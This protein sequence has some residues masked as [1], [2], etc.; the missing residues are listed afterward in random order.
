[1]VSPQIAKSFTVQA[2]AFEDAR[3]NQVLGG[4]AGWLF[5]A[6]TLQPDDL[7]LDVAAG[8]GH[9]ARALASRVRAVVAVDATEAMLAAGQAAA[10]REGLSN[11]IFTRGDA[12]ALPF[13]DGSFTAA[14]CRYAVHHFPDPAAPLAEMARCL[15]R[16]GR[17]VVADLVT[18]GD[19]AVA[20]RTDELERLRDPSHERLRSSD[21]LAD[22]VRATGARVTHR[23][24]RDVKRPVS[25]WLALTQT[26]QGAAAEIVSQLDAELA[27]GPAT[28]LV[29]CRNAGE[30]WFTQ[31]YTSITASL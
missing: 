8:T 5:E 25:D 13:L 31:T 16:P 30:L 4:G 3:F 14:V 19:P 7:L 24:S 21:Q 12:A 22:L 26:E 1:M 10:M 9:A 6:L 23:A 29:P 20:E 15:R 28:G 17:L 11:L 18:D 2:P 27:G